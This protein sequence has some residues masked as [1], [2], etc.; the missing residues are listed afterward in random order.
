VSHRILL[1]LPVVATI[2]CASPAPESDAASSAALTQN[3]ALH[4]FY[5]VLERPCAVDALPAGMAPTSADAT[6][7][8]RARIAE[9]EADQAKLK[10]D[11]EARGAKIVATFS[12]LANAFQVLAPASVGRRLERLPGV[13]RVEP[14]PIFQRSLASALPVM[15][16][17]AAWS[18]TTPYQGDGIT[19]GTIDTGIDY[20]HAD[21]GGA[22]TP[23]AYLANDSTVI[24]A[25]TFPT[26]KVVGGWDFVGDDYDAS[27][28]N[29]FPVQDPDPLDCVKPESGFI[30]GGHGTHVAGIAAG[31]GVQS[32]GTTFAGSYDQ[33]LDLKS[34]D[35][36][37]GVAPRAKLYSLKVFGCTG[38]TSA[39]GQAL[40]RAADPNKD[41]SFDDRLDVVNASLGTSYGLEYATT[42]QLVSNLAKVGTVLAVAAGN[43]GQEF[44]SVAS[45]AV[46]RE[47]I[48]VAASSDNQ[49]VVLTVTAP[50]S[51]ADDYVASEAGATKPLA[52]VGVV[53]GALVPASPNNGC[54]PLSNAAA[55]AGNLVLIERGACK[56]SSKFNNAINAGASAV[57][58]IDDQDEVLPFSVGGGD[59]GSLPIPG[60]MIR[61]ADGDKLKAAAAQ[62]TVSAQLDPDKPYAGPGTELLAGYSSRGPAPL[63]DLL[64]PEISAPG[65]HIDSARVGS[66]TAARRSDGT[67]M[68]C[69]FVAGAAALV[70]EAHPEFS[71]GEV[72]AALMN[73]A[74]AIKGL[75]DQQ[76]SVS[77]QGSG[78][79]AVDR[80]VDLTVIAGTDL[81]NGEVGVS[82]GSLTAAAPVSTK[83]SFS[84]DNHGTSDA[85]LAL[86]VEPSFVLPGV[87]VAA[88]PS[89]LSIP[90]GQSATVELELSFD[91]SALG[92]PGVDPGTAPTENSQPRHYLH[93]ASGLVRLTSTTPAYDLVVPY[94]GNLRAA[95]H[96]KAAPPGDCDAPALTGTVSIPIGGDSPLPSPVVS[97]FQLGTLDPARSESDTDPEIAMIDLLAVGV[98]TNL[99]VADSFDTASVYFGV[100]VKGE[101]TTPARGPYSVV[102]IDVDTDQ[103]GTADYEIR[104]EPLTALGPY[105]DVLVANTYDLTTQQ[106]SQTSRFIN[107][108]DAATASSQPFHNS[109]LV[110]PAFLIDLGLSADHTVFDYV[111]ESGNPNDPTLAERTDWVTFDAAHPAVDTVKSSPDARPVYL[112]DGPVKVDIAADAPDDAKKLLLLHHN[113]VPGERFEVLDLVRPGVGNAAVTLSAPESIASTDTATALVTVQNSGP[114]AVSDA[115]LTGT[116][117]GGSLQAASA[118]QGSCGSGAS[119]DCDLGPLDAGASAT[120]TLTLA[121]K[122]G[123]ATLS[124]SSSVDSGLPCETST[125][126]NQASADIAV[127]GPKAKSND[128][129]AEGGGC[130]C[131]LSADPSRS[132]GLVALALAALAVALRRRRR[133]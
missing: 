6:R 129:T 116:L 38:S 79:L 81:A 98:A 12:R 39:M 43:D 28:T 31:M 33:S 17:P 84:V 22:G 57:V 66:G 49:F 61:K 105:S 48:A 108:V 29:P 123:V 10:P 102:Y 58:L 41:G 128:L 122:D 107:V 100:A 70:R 50:S 90:A 92:D 18:K 13:V 7:I 106:P 115:K 68:A 19:I 62:A 76:Y 130:G 104:A 9:I 44:Y 24:E 20:T 82:F 51:V 118:S 46:F 78:R 121:P 1:W 110:L 2:A 89:S 34:F 11:L 59:P 27:G 111:A 119:I 101:W 124:V 99:S 95:A 85:T 42:G 65:S 69:P 75:S 40:E 25:G 131:R 133:S 21:F 47:P 114:V 96:R 60:V 32:D 127:N 103:N 4:D 15:G 16:A 8:A 3:A 117:S 109:V 36:A 112:G 86:A 71:P 94:L 74:Q 35:V 26:A 37:P 97:A 93:E 23:D 120:V 45:P 52:S 67:S 14:V 55:V 73:G 113:N 80:S 54:Q 88:T 126:D 5:V 56:T 30:A 77:S 53:T 83:K 91:P 132:R 64:K 72:K 125:T 63:D 87:S